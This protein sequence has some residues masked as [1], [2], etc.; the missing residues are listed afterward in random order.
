MDFIRKEP[1][2]GKDDN[3]DEIDQDLG[4]VDPEDVAKQGAL[5]YQAWNQRQLAQED[6]DQVPVPLVTKDDQTNNHKSLVR[7]VC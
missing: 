2:P 5:A 4:D 3:K 7:G 6:V 1:L